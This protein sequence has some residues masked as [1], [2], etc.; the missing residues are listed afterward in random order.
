VS[1][2]LYIIEIVV[3][4]GLI[5]LVHELGHFL[6]AKAFGV[7]VRKFAMGMGPIIFKWGKGET[8]YSVRWVPVGGFVDLVGEHPEADEADDPRGLWRRPAWQRII[9]FSAGVFMNAVL[10]LAV[11]TAAPMVGVQAPVPVIGDV[12]PGTPAKVAGLQTGDRILSINGHRIESFDEFQFAVLLADAGTT[13][14]LEIERPAAGSETPKLLTFDVA[15]VSTGPF[16]AIGV[17]AEAET[18]IFRMLVESAAAQAGLKAGDRVLAVNGRPVDSWHDLEE[19]VKKAPPRQLALSIQRGEQTLDLAVNFADVKI[20]NL[21]F[22]LP[23][24]IHSVQDKSPAAEAGLK[25]GDILVSFQGVPWP[26]GVEFL[27]A[28][29]RVPAGEAVHLQVQRDGQIVDLTANL[30]VLHGAGYP[31]L[32]T[33]IEE[34]TEAPL[35]VGSVNADGPALAAGLHPGDVILKAGSAGMEVTDWKSLGAAMEKN[36]GP[37]FPM[38]VRRG[39]TQLDFTIPL[40]HLSLGG[41]TAQPKY[42]ELPRVYN[43]ID[44][45]ERGVRRTGL[46]FARVYV[47]I[48]QLFTGEVSTETTAGPVGIV[49]VSLVIASRGLGTF[50]DFLGILTVSIAVLNFLPIPPFDGGHVLFVVIDKIIRKPVRLKTRN[51]VWIVGWGLVLALFLVVTYHDIVRVVTQWISG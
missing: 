25:V 38:T 13:F 49:Q 24:K 6:S 31:R 26:S 3:G 11:F 4:L 10:A 1:T 14:K 12:L 32:G 8:E 47:S 46:W 40:E 2:F 37:V 9:V 18:A 20:Y 51:I 50:L 35:R 17:Q 39:E 21:G 22:D 19:A 15:S 5:I 36:E 28:V 44:A 42:F 7:R 48:K 45:A 43:P 30:A 29:Q 16:P 27:D 34:A 33:K 23:T 41:A